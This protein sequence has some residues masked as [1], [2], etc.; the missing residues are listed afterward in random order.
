V[1]LTKQQSR[2]RWK[3]LCD[4]AFERDPCG[5]VSSECQRDE[6][7]CLADSVMRMLENM[8]TRNE[9]AAYLRRRLP[10]HFGVTNLSRVD[11]FSEAV[12]TWY[13]TK[14]PNTTVM[15]GLAE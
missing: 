14:W 6:Y 2:E 8:A 12:K 3:Q 10:E 5:L 4:L 1:K 15:E 7:D 13:D 11:R 9:I